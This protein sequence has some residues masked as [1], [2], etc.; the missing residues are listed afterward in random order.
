[1]ECLGSSLWTMCVPSIIVASFFGLPRLDCATPSRHL[2]ESALF[3]WLLL[4]FSESDGGHGQ[5]SCAKKASKSPTR[6]WQAMKSRRK[7]K[8]Q[9]SWKSNLLL[10]STMS[11]C[12]QNWTRAVCSTLLL[13]LLN[14]IDFPAWQSSV[15]TALCPSLLPLEQI[16]SLLLT[17]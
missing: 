17:S 13:H 5:S 2:T 7:A 3:V 12:S 10:P 1:M 4:W 15:E 16:L 9:P 6:V 14:L 11:F 8:Y